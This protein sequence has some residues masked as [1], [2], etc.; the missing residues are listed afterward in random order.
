MSGMETRA[1]TATIDVE[2][3]RQEVWRA[4]TTTAGI[5]TFFAADCHADLRPGGAYEVYFD[6]DAEPGDQGA[7]GTKI[8]ALHPERMLSFTWNFPAEFDAIREQRTV[9]IVRLAPI[10]A[11]KTSVTL[12]QVGW[13][14]GGQ[15]DEAFKYFERAWGEVVLPRLQRRFQDG[16]IDW[17]R[18]K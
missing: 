2:A 7:E 10:D 15:W 16:P 12:R 8:L 13:G 9:V 14:E 11:E 1:V 3:D 4:W 6:P 17:E 5:T 18:T